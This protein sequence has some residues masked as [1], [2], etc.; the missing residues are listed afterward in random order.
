M[1]GGTI[2]PDRFK[3]PPHRFFLERDSAKVPPTSGDVQEDHS[4]T[5]AE[6]SRRLDEQREAIADRWL[7]EVC[8][9]SESVDGE[10][11]ALIREFLHLLASLLAPGLGA[12]RDQVEVTLQQAAELY[13]N[14]GAHRGLAAGESVEEVQLLRG[15]LLRF[16]YSLPQGEGSQ[17]VSLRDLLQLNR[18]VDLG[19]TY[20]SVGHTDTLFFN[21][22]HGTGVSDAPTPELLA[23]VR[24]QI[25]GIRAELSLLA[26]P[27]GQEA[28]RRPTQ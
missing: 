16:L 19:A 26:T 6:L 5:P 14:L 17:G 7:L 18:L 2:H 11:L 24:E 22:F 1:S 27:E 20:A 15:I 21:L 8:S 12:F 13:G 25:A 3:S 10:L 28:P 4:L 9:R 23:E